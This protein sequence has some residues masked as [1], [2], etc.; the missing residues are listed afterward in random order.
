MLAVAVSAQASFIG[1]TITEQDGPVTVAAVVTS[2]SSTLD[3]VAINITGITGGSYL[4]G[5]EGVWTAVGG[6]IALNNEVSQPSIGD[7]WNLYTVQGQDGATGPQ[8]WIN[9]ASDTN[10]L[11]NGNP[12][13]EGTSLGNDSNSG[14]PLYASFADDYFSTSTASM[15]RGSGASSK[16][17]FATL[18]VQDSVT[19]LSFGD[20]GL[21]P[22]GTSPSEVYVYNNVLGQTQAEHFTVGAVTLSTPEPS[23]MLLLASGLMGLL[24]YAWRKRK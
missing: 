3:K 19:S 2:Y 10:A 22:N 11:S 1:Q 17:L 16:T 6:G 24:C 14:V 12:A 5:I 13:Y 4:T 9:E 8:S 23:T 21:G 20:E 18:Y 15:P 7:P